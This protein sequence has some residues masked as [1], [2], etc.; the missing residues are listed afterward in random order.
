VERVNVIDTIYPGV[1]IVISGVSKEIKEK[2]KGVTFYF[3]GDGIKTKQYE[4]R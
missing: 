1:T 4:G 2:M 3:E